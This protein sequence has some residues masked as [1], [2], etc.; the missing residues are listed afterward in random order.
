LSLEVVDRGHQVLLVLEENQGD[1]VGLI[2]PPISLEFSLHGV[3]KNIRS[4]RRHP[5]WWRW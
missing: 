1:V 2:S 5:P 4:G 3:W